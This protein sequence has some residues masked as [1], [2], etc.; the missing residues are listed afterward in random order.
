MGEERTTTATAPLETTTK[1]LRVETKGLRTKGLQ[2]PIIT[3]E[4]RATTMVRALAAAARAMVRGPGTSDEEAMGREGGSVESILLL[5]HLSPGDYS[6]LNPTV[7]I[8][9]T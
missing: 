9:A 4:L 2:V 3:K 7:G 6:A 8:E 1:G 5:V